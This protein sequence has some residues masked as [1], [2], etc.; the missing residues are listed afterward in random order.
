M[1]SSSNREDFQECWIAPLIGTERFLMTCSVHS[2]PVIISSR[3]PNS[4]LFLI[5]EIILKLQIASSSA[6]DS[7]SK[8][9]TR[10]WE[11]SSRYFAQRS[12]IH[13]LRVFG[14]VKTHQTNSGIFCQI[15]GLSRPNIPLIANWIICDRDSWNSWIF[16]NLELM[17]TRLQ[18]HKT[19]RR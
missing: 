18:Y 14:L 6:R 11:I 9:E 3:L 13:V 17:K 16:G 7:T 8:L 19:V 1:N 12:R 2:R 15:V 5:W 4:P 10:P